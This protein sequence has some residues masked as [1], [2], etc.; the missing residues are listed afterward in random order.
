M[1]ESM[2]LNDIYQPLDAKAHEISDLFH[3]PVGW[4]NGHYRRDTSGGTTE[5]MLEGIRKSAEET[6]FFSFTFPFDIS[7]GDMQEFV[8]FLRANGFFY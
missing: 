4:F 8:D 2:Y 6:I 5:A 7:P 3:C 1:I